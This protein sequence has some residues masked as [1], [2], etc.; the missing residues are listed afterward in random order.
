MGKGVLELTPLCS[1][2]TGEDASHALE[3]SAAPNQVRDGGGGWSLK[4]GGAE[5][6]S[7][8]RSSKKLEC[9]CCSLAGGSGTLPS[10]R[11]PQGCAVAKSDWEH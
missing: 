11:G 1:L 2:T 4:W 8:P 5:V 3:G 6:P 10:S 7:S 9:T